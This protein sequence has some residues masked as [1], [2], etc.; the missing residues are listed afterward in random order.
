[1]TSRV[2]SGVRVQV[3]AGSTTP[4]H[5]GPVWHLS[6]I[7]ASGKMQV[8]MEKKMDSLG[9]VFKRSSRPQI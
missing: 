5:E 6:L 9:H 4:T 2:L 1:M 7:L 8:V 3:A